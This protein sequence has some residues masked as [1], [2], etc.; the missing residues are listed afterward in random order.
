MAKYDVELFLNDIKTI[1]TSHLN[2]KIAAINSEKNDT[3]TLGSINNNAYFLQTLDNDEAN[4]DPYVLYGIEDIKTVGIGPLSGHE[5]T[6][7][8]VIVVADHQDGNC[9]KKMMRY[10]RALEEVFAE[11]FQEN[12]HGTKMEIQ[13]IVPV[14]FKALNTSFRYRAIG[15]ALRA[16]LVG[17]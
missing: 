13:S 10:Q 7:A 4:F 5:Y 15:V 11:H 16:H 14:S 6:I 3:I 8:I 2:T 1:L 17:G 9:A 12:E